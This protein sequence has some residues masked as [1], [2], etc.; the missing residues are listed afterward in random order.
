MDVVPSHA[1]SIFFLSA[2][3]VYIPLNVGEA[4]MK[5]KMGFMCALRFRGKSDS[6]C[7]RIYEYN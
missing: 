6:I 2:F 4:Q 7:D 3:V 1:E 5:K